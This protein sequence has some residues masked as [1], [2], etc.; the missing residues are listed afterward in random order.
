[1]L[2]PSATSQFKSNCNGRRF[3]RAYDMVCYQTCSALYLLIINELCDKFSNKKE[4][5]RP[6]RQLILNFICKVLLFNFI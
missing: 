3:G 5:F 2:K 4:A 6:I 1:M